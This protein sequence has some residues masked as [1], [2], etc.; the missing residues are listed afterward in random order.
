MPLKSVIAS[1]EWIADCKCKGPILFLLRNTFIG[2]SND[3]VCR[4]VESAHK[5]QIFLRKLTASDNFPAVAVKHVQLAGR[6]SKPETATKY[7]GV[8]PH[9]GIVRRKRLLDM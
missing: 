8:R 4:S 1:W 6:L 9:N 7:G 5:T 2:K 3:L